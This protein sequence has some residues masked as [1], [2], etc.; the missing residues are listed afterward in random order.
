MPDVHSQN[1]QKPVTSTT[2]LLI[3]LWK[4]LAK[5]RRRQLVLVFCLMLASAFAEVVSLGA[6]LPFIGVLTAPEKV[7][8]YPSLERFVEEFGIQ[9]MAKKQQRR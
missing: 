7:L 3:G 5:S 9:R 6:V 4:R 8:K 1:D 2:K